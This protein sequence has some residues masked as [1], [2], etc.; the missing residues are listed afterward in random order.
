MNRCDDGSCTALEYLRTDGEWIRLPAMAAI[1][2][3]TMTRRAPHAW[4]DIPPRY[5]RCRSCG[6]TEID[7]VLVAP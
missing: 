1:Q 4:E 7:L 5:R 3:S 6:R 2:V